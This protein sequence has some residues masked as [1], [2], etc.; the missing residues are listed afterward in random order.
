LGQLVEAMCYKPESVYIYTDYYTHTM[1]W[2]KTLLM[3]KPEV[4]GFDSRWLL[5]EIFIN[6]IL[7]AAL[8]P[9]D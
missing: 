7:P 1:E 3:Y 6:V 8:W 9:C 2:T 5:L 4:R